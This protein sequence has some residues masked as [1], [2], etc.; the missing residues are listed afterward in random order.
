MVGIQITLT[1]DPLVLM[2][3]VRW[4]CLFVL[5]TV[6]PLSAQRPAP[7]TDTVRSP[8]L[9]AEVSDLP[10]NIDGELALLFEEDDGTSVVH[11]IG[12][13]SL[14]LGEGEGQ[15]VQSREAVIWI[16]N[17]GAQGAKGRRYQVILWQD[18][19]VREFGGT[20]TT[21][22]ALFVTLASKGPLTIATDDYANQSSLESRA[23][24]YGQ[25]I[26]QE[27]AKGKSDILT[28]KSS[29]SVIDTTGL[30]QKPSAPGIKPVITFRTEGDLTGPIAGGT[31]QYVTVIG[32]VHLSRGIPGT[33]DYLEIR[34]ARVVVYLPGDAEFP[35]LAG[36]A[37][38]GAMGGRGD[39]SDREAQV[40]ARKDKRRRNN[41][42][43]LS[44]SFGDVEV[45]AVY[46]EGDV[47]MMQGP[48][49]IRAARLYYDL[50]RDKALIL[51]AVIRVMDPKRNIPLYVRAEEI[52]QLSTSEFSASQAIL[53]TSE[54]HTPHYHIGAGYIE[55]INRTP[56]SPT[57]GRTVRAGSF[58]IEDATLN[59]GG[60]PIAYWPYIR[61]SVDTSETALRRV[62]T[63]FSNYFG[64]ELETSW[65]LF[66]V[67]DLQR[68]DGFDG[69][70]NFDS[71]S[72]RGPAIGVDVNYQRDRYFGLVKS[73]LL[74]DDGKDFLG[75][76]RERQSQKDIRGRFL[77]RHRQYLEDDWE[78]TLEVSYISNEGFLEEF[79]ER[80]FDND[81]EQETLLYLKKQRENWAFTA[82][83]QG[84][85][86]D[87]DTQTERL[88]DLAFYQV[89]E[90]LRGGV[91]WYSEWRTGLVR[92]RPGNQ[93]FKEFLREG[94]LAGSGSVLRSDTRQELTYP[95]DV[96]P[97]RL[98]PYVVVR[99]TT[100]DDTPRHG[101]LQR[102]YGAAGL[103][104]SLYLSH[105]DRDVKS[106][107][108]DL[109]G[110]RHIVKVDV[111]AWASEANYTRDELF[112]F[113]DTVE[114]INDTDG[115]LI[116]VRQRWQ[117]K[118]GRDETRRTVD[119]LTL[120]V[121][122]GFFN[123]RDNEDKTNG[124]IPLS[125]PEESVTRNFAN[126]SLIWRMNDRTALVNEMNF[127][128]NDAQLDIWNLSFV[129]D[130]SP[131]L[132][133][134][135]GYRFIEDTGSNLLAMDVNYRFTE[136]HLL[137]L[138]ERFD[139]ARGQTLDF[140]VA[141][142]RKFPRWFGAISFELDEAEND[143]GVSFSLWPEGLP[144]A[145]LG[146]RRFTGLATSTRVLNK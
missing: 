14:Q 95:V 93:S 38:A 51:D 1:T 86:L 8:L 142:V 119:V 41:R 32:G 39:V 10:V 37:G 61:G 33:N 99:G 65:H 12:D 29:L 128:V 116:G 115:V 130:R 6:M 64:L 137:A 79:F 140:T 48:N 69:K 144:K 118:R 2:N 66:H 75:R 72:E 92:Y 127:D 78:L 88:P 110:L 97:V 35:S 77:L 4:I 108:F 34:A 138:R 105:L 82:T 94:Q 54:F 106:S 132:S 87:Y 96:G 109:D 18:A 98:I 145:A 74:S 11:V 28:T 59:I 76:Q 85:I 104:G 126:T 101:G 120:D 70:L 67:L 36:S 20:I 84:R 26:R 31:H 134:L 131:R 50:L 27:L 91:N 133:Y 102:I 100:W 46:L 60:T 21:G 45:E 16:E 139:L 13:F 117:T 30:A 7:L 44:G 49:V 53:T 114:G 25:K 58:R 83:L 112:Q 56:A 55:L 63:G 62:R 3:H 9:P 135:L 90:P 123:D 136:K 43:T 17:L 22:P 80:E 5:L 42:P 57:G 124:F 23:Y 89:G 125:R 113:D 141:L 143:F 129:I 146:S 122:A 71:Y 68:P 47:Q 121:E 52:R 24:R 107:I 19:Q 81:K 103:R 111:A 15:I 40:K 73:Y